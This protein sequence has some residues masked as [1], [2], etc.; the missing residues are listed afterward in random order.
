M[1]PKYAGVTVL[2]RYTLRLLTLDQLS[3]AAALVCALEL[4]R[5]ENPRE[6]GNWPFEI[7]LWVGSG[8][9][10]QLHG[11]AGRRIRRGLEGPRLQARPGRP[12]AG[13]AREMPLVRRRPSRRTA[14]TSTPTRTTPRSC[15]SPA[16]ATVASS[17]ATGS[18]PIHMV[19]EP[20]YQRAA[21]LPDR[22]GRQVRRHAVE[23]RDRQALRPCQELSSE[24]SGFW[25]DC[26]G[27]TGVELDE[28]LPPPELVIQDEL[29]LIS[30][31]LGTI[32]GLFET[33]IE[34]LCRDKNAGRPQDRVVDGH[35]A[36]G[37]RPDP[38]FVRTSV[39]ADF[40]AAR[41]ESQRLVLRDDRA[42]IRR[43][44]RGCTWAWRLRGE[45][46]SECS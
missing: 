9:D 32:A 35:G 26:D 1:I 12:T 25:G 19:D 38:R 22:H 8:G 15:G 36:P 30:G 27:E 37:D 40:P 46:P 14:F 42:G 6:L 4:M 2:M 23:G 29:H 10:A 7:G 31:P 44:R 41:A 18:L 13:S 3:R 24:A 28:Y 16:W 21:R 39:G 33:A 11:Q 34:S 17:P 43:A 5:Q 20:I 45:V